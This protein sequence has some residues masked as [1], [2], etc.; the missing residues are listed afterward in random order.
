M[1]GDSLT[2]QLFIALACNAVTLYDGI[3]NHVEVHWKDTFP[4]ANDRLCKIPGGEHS[5]FDA[6]SVIFKGGTELHFV[7][8][9]GGRD[10]HTSKA[11]VLER[12]AKEVQSTGRVTFGE[13]TALP[14][15]M[16]LVLLC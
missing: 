14:P 15:G 4:C 13:K 5:G 2:R 8:H 16:C 6:A 11:N 7:P 12:L 1:T 9:H 10:G 3:V